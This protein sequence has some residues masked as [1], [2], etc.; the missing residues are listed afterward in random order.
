MIE[1]IPET[2]CLEMEVGWLTTNLNDHK[3][4]PDFNPSLL[5]SISLLSPKS[6]KKDDR[7]MSLCRYFIIKYNVVVRNA[8]LLLSNCSSLPHLHKLSRVNRKLVVRGFTKSFLLKQL[9]KQQRQLGRK[10]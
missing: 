3:I 6:R 1:V 8:L 9:Q 7:E 4:F 10:A 2:R 5:I